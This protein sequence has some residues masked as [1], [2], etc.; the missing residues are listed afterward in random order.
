MLEANKGKW[1]NKTYDAILSNYEKLSE[2]SKIVILIDGN[3]A[4]STEEFLLFARQSTKVTLM[5]KNTS[6]TLD[7]SNVLEV[8]FSCMPYI[9]R[10]SSSRSNR[11]I[12]GEGIDNTGIKP[13][14]YLSDKDDWMEKAVVFLEK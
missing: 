13:Q 6:G 12:H 2:P 1:V 9:L 10:Y 7:Y 3:C 14:Y 8:P 11:V 4:S 5:G